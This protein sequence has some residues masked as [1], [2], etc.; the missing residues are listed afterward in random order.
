MSVG[1]S[2]GVGVEVSVGVEVGVAVVVGAGW[3]WMILGVSQNPWALLGYLLLQTVRRM[4]ST[5]CP[6]RELRS[7]SMVVIPPP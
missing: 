1:V 5:F 7:I 2:V 3:M 6:A 4:N